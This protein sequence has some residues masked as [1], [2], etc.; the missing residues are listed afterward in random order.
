MYQLGKVCTFFNQFQ[1]QCYKQFYLPRMMNIDEMMIKTKF[2]FTKC[3]IRNLKKSIHD[4]IKIEA[5]CDLRI[6][7]SFTL[8]MFIR[9]Q[10]KIFF[11]LD[12]KQ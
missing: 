12:Q 1:I 5:L 10:T 4:G 9:L 3:K 2:K 11:K 7:Y 6:G 8:F